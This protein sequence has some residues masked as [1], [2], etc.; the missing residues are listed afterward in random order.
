MNESLDADK[1]TSSAD[2]AYRRLVE[3][4]MMYSIEFPENI[5]VKKFIDIIGENGVSRS[6]HL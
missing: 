3:T 1:I 6:K 5:N 2:E 4:A